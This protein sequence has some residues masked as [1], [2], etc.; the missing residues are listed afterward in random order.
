MIYWCFTEPAT[1]LILFCVFFF[2]DPATT[3]IYTLSLH[4]ALPISALTFAAWFAF[5]PDPRFTL[6]LQTFIAV[7]II[8]CPCALSLATPTAIMVGTGKG[9]EAGVLIRGGKA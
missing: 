8:A 5:G 4:D 7:L 3:E 9:A 6:A 1:T 2:N